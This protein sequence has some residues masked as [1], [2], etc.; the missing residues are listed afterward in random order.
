VAVI[1]GSIG[2]QAL[3]AGLVDEVHLNLVPAL[4]RSG[5][6][7]SGRLRRWHEPFDDQE[8]GVTDDKVVVRGWA[9]EYVYDELP[10]KRAL[11]DLRPIDLRSG[12]SSFLRGFAAMGG[13]QRGFAADPGAGSVRNARKAGGRAANKD[14]A[15]QAFLRERR[16]S[17]PRPPA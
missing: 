15:L 1:A 8:G 16:D 17:N 10:A 11:L 9:E 2:G 3:E 7:F 14:A 5:V 6:R 12:G 13:R 4:L